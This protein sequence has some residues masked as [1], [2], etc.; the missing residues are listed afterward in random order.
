MRFVLLTVFV[1]NALLTNSFASGK[2]IYSDRQTFS[3]S[4]TTGKIQDPENTTDG[5]LRNFEVISLANSS[6]VIEQTLH[7]P[8]GGGYGITTGILI[9]SM[10]GQVIDNETLSGLIL[11]TTYF[12]SNNEDYKTAEE[13][14]IVSLGEGKYGIEYEVTENFNA[15]VIQFK[16]TNGISLT[17]LKVYYGYHNN[18]P[19]PVTLSS[20]TASNLG[21][22]VKL[23]WATKTE[24]NS[25]Y[26]EI[27]KSIDGENF[28]TVESVLSKGSS[29][30]GASYTFT[31]RSITEGTVYYRLKQVDQNGEYEFSRTVSVTVE[32]STNDFSVFPNP[33]E[34]T[35]INV[36]SLNSGEEVSL[37]IFREDGS[38]QYQ[39]AIVSTEGMMRI[40]PAAKLLPGTYIVRLTSNGSVSQKRFVVI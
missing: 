19:V 39:T 29:S 37:S 13:F 35:F 6:A 20:F 31:D 33:S 34:G 28:L 4:A 21:S 7:F 14:R 11:H 17:D 9:E 27:Q 1:L 36:A 2:R 23:D 24:F 3:I 10:N 30:S 40:E 5:D 12:D 18:V 16:N 25:N 15:I 26:F 22:S 32:K 38:L 8:F